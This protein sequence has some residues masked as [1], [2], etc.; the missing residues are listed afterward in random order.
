M[1][2][3]V[4]P[5]LLLTQNE[6]RLPYP[7]LS[8]EEV[9]ALTARLGSDHRWLWGQPEPIRHMLHLPLF[10]IVATLRQQ[11]GAEIPVLRGRSWT[12]SLRLRS[13]AATGRLTRHGRRSSRSPG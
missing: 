1:R 2:R 8:D 4:R 10:L 5:G 3:P 9:A 6:V 13:T 12:P 11:A 7:A